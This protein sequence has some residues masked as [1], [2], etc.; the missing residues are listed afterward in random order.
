MVSIL[1]FQL[2][3]YV[4]D[5]SLKLRYDGN[6]VALWATFPLHWLIL[7]ASGLTVRNFFLH[8]AVLKK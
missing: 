6:I 5:L 7:L 1:W 8:F 2:Y 3:F 4:D